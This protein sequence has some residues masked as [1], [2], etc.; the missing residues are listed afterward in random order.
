M[1][2]IPKLAISNIAWNTQDD[3]KI[4][5][6]LNKYSFTGLEIAPTKLFPNIA[7]VQKNEIVTY[8]N[9]CN[10]YKI[11]IVAMQSLLFGRPDLTIFDSKEKR[12][13]LILYLEHIIWIGYMLGVEYIVFGSPKNRI[14]PSTLSVEDV[15]KISIEF[16]SKLGDIAKK[17]NMYFCIETNPSFYGTNF[18]TKSS[19]AITLIKKVNHSHF[20]FH[21]D[22]G[23]LFSNNENP[24]EIITAGIKYMKHCHISDKN[25]IPLTDG[26]N[27]TSK[28]KEV[29]MSLNDAGY[30]GWRSVEMRQASE[31]EIENAQIIEKVVSFVQGIYGK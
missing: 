1:Q 12:N 3:K 25:L 4:F 5:K 10:E 7:S 28:H 11:K 18:I 2:L 20:R 30:T 22:T 29:A 26:E 16:F 17:Y 23:A 21:L 9:I 8:K 27:Y 24:S 15:D 6:I 19:Q 13:D 14:I 31:N